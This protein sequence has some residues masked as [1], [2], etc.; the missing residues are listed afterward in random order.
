[1]GKVIQELTGGRQAVST[2]ER[3]WFDLRSLLSRFELQVDTVA[4]SRGKIIGATMSE[5][6]PGLY[7]GNPLCL[8]DIL[9]NLASYTLFCLDEEGV[10]FN[11][12]ASPLE[13]GQYRLE[14]TVTTTGSGIPPS[15]LMQIFQPASREGWQGNSSLYIAKTLARLLNGD[16]SIENTSGWGTR[17]NLHVVMESGITEPVF[18]N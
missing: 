16:L 12:Q 9:N 13:G 7:L 4:Q 18:Y 6:M 1:M 2:V 15:R 5:E 11:I 14:I 17:Y 8:N 3:I 10:F